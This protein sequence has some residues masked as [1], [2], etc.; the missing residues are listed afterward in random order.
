MLLYSQQRTPP[1]RRRLEQPRPAQEQGR[2]LYKEEFGRVHAQG[3]NMIQRAKPTPRHVLSQTR[4]DEGDGGL[5]TRRSQRGWRETEA[6]NRSILLV[7]T[8]TAS[9]AAKAVGRTGAT[10]WRQCLHQFTGLRVIVHNDDGTCADCSSLQRTSCITRG[11]TAR[12]SCGTRWRRGQ[13]LAI[14]VCK[15]LL[16]EHGRPVL[17]RRWE[18]CSS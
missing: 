9:K 13:A 4:Q 15:S 14:L 2:V 6:Q 17:G 10:A 3:V 5:P 12:F 1:T 7:Q 18:K 11:P 16:R 8:M